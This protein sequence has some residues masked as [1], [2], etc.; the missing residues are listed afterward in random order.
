MA[1]LKNELINFAK[2]WDQLKKTLPESYAEL[3]NLINE[4]EDDD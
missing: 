2:N 4:L 3:Y 1:E